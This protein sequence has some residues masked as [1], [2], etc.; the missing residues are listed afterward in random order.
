MKKLTVL[1]IFALCLAG[2]QEAAAQKRHPKFRYPVC[3]DGVVPPGGTC[4]CHSQASSGYQICTP[5]KY[6]QTFGGVCS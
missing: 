4:E 1:L 5:G 2:S 3:R 6:C